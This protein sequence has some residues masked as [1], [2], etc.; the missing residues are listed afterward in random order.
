MTPPLS[1]GLAAAE[2]DLPADDFRTLAKLCA[3]SPATPV[4]DNARG[5]D[6]EHVSTRTRA[7]LRQL[8]MVAWLAILLGIAMQALSLAGRGSV[9]AH[10]TLIQIGVELAENVAWSFFVCAGIG[11]GSLLG[12]ARPAL[13]GLIGAVSA[14]LA[15][16][17]AKGSQKVLAGAA[18]AAEKPFIMSL[19][20]LGVLRALEYGLLGWAL[21][22]LTSRSDARGWHFLVAGMLAGIVFGGSI[23][24]LTIDTAAARGP[25]MAPAQIVATTINEM[26]FPIGC[27][28]VVYIALRIGRQI[29]LVATD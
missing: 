24:W 10:P 1:N 19:M 4:N 11:L 9:G 12:K 13:G 27:A 5:L 14:P 28:L 23:T 2:F 8:T 17:L 20:T 16:G 15:M 6:D 26:I 21:A 18:G 25:A 3:Q 7:I 29:K 22:W